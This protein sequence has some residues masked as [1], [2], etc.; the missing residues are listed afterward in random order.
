MLPDIVEPW[1]TPS[2]QALASLSKM[3]VP[4]FLMNFGVST[5][6]WGFV[7]SFQ[8]LKAGGSGHPCFHT[9][10]SS[11]AGGEVFTSQLLL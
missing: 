4:F 2:A 6:P 7:Q 11:G 5:Y 1:A 8:F 10:Q 9:F 3:G